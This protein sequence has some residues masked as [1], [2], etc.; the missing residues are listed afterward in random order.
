MLELTHE[1]CE[2]LKATVAQQLCPDKE[3]ADNGYRLYQTI[4]ISAIRA[5]IETIRE[6]EKM[7]SAQ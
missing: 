2:A 3:D 1:E 4:T 5:T 7:K 6:Y